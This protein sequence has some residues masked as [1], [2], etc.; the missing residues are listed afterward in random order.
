MCS[1]CNDD[2]SLTCTTN[3]CRDCV[4][5]EWQE[6]SP[7]GTTCGNS[8]RVRVR[9]FTEPVGN[10][11]PCMEGVLEFDRCV[12]DPCPGEN[13]PPPLTF[14]KHYFFLQSSSLCLFYPCQIV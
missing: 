1:T 12:Q 3:E 8:N 7:C 9:N 6:W 13:R 5:D 11:E 2:A 4:Y 14:L 10:G